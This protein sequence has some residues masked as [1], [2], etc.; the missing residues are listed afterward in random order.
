MVKVAA[1]KWRGK[2][3]AVYN[4]MDDIYDNSFWP[5]HDD[6]PLQE[7][8]R[9]WK[10]DGTAWTGHA[11]GGDDLVERLPNY[12][13]GDRVRATGDEPNG[14]CGVVVKVGS[15]S[16]SLKVRFDDW[17]GGRGEGER[18][19]WTCASDL[20]AAPLFKVGDRVRSLVNRIDV[21]RGG[22][23]TVVDL[24]ANRAGI[25]IVDDAGDQHLLNAG[26]V[27]HVTAATP[28][29]EAGK[30]YK[31][32]GGR[33]VG[34]MEETGRDIEGE[35]DGKDRCYS[36]SGEHLFGDDSLNI[37]GEWKIEA[38]RYYKTRD[39]RKVGPMQV[40]GHNNDRLREAIGDGRFWMF[41]GK[42]HGD[43][44]LIA[45]WSDAPVASATGAA[46]TGRGCAAAEVD[47]Q[48]DEY[49][50][51]ASESKFKVGDRVEYSDD[52]CS[53]V[54][55]ISGKNGVLYHNGWFVK[56]DE[57]DRIFCPFDGGTTRIF[58]NAGLRLVAPAIS[59]KFKVGDE[60][61]HKSLGYTG[62]VEC[63]VGV[64]RVKTYWTDEGWGATDPISE[65]ELIKP[66]PTQ[67]AIVALI[68]NGQ[69]KPSSWPFVHANR[70]LAA[71]EAGRLACKHPG[72]EF[73]VY[74]LVDTH[75]EAKV[76]EHEWQRL[77]AEGERVRACKELR[78]LAGVSLAAAVKAVDAIREAA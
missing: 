28:T 12:K 64:D 16:I 78:D 8:K 54:G 22:E 76:Y 40:F 2:S 65:L 23:Y 32:K 62:V 27:E 3:G 73:G 17:T 38:G 44:D 20:E 53:G 43:H 5:F 60:V 26:E 49:G 1:G 75:R 69:P 47:N 29:I 6:A 63:L 72:K 25:W 36:K 19:W 34:P 15:H 61:R 10:S 37:V 59:G 41:D 56:V 67:P 52:K 46:A 77:A 7:D 33:R 9:F 74:E 58:Y 35:V 55:V 14:H 68:E 31:T 21:T 50:G 51:A 48:R 4:V 11:D 42:G 71:K 39:G 70:E 30:F 57:K 18:Y 24:P 45:E 13:V 66:S